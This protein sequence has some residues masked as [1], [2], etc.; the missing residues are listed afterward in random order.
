MNPK[1]IWLTI[2]DVLDWARNFVSKP[3]GGFVTF[4][5]LVVS[6]A[7]YGDYKQ[8][9]GYDK[10]R[11]TNKE[12]EAQNEQ[13]LVRRDADIV[14]LERQLIE[15]QHKIDTLQ[16][17]L[18]TLDCTEQVNK[19]LN[20][21]QVMQ[22]KTAQSAAMAEREYKNKVRSYELEEQKTRELEQTK[23]QLKK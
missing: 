15:K 4:V 2:R 19:Y 11:L 16:H 3:F 20:I 17:R 13:R 6:A 5:A 8:D 23:K 18:N 14:K 21:I 10:G 9:V 12:I 1:T 22:I 7:W